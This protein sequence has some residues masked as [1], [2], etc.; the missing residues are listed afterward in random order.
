MSRTFN[1]APR[2]YTRS[3]KQCLEEKRR[4]LERERRHEQIALSREV[5]E[6]MQGVDTWELATHPSRRPVAAT[7]TADGVAVVRTHN[8]SVT[9][10][11]L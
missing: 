11:F 6:A 9:N 7:A 4:R 3:S 10:Y 5:A 2:K 8:G 1:D